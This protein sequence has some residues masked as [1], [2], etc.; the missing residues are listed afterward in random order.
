LRR[1]S[2]GF[3][4]KVRR[5][6]TAGASSKPATATRLNRNQ[7]DVN[8]GKTS[9]SLWHGR[10]AAAW[11]CE[12]ITRASAGA[13]RNAGPLTDAIAGRNASACHDA[14]ACCGT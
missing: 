7:D 8:S 6:A 9:G 2:A 1:R 4:D 11:L 12:R 5:L 13:C 10:T 3:S 14:G